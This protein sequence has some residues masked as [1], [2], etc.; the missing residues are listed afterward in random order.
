MYSWVCQIFF[1][2]A[3]AIVYW[4]WWMADLT[5]DDSGII[6]LISHVK[7]SSFSSK[8]Y[9]SVMDKNNYNRICRIS[10]K[11]EDI[12]ESYRRILSLTFAVWITIS[13]LSQDSYS[14]RINFSVTPGFVRMVSGTSFKSTI[15]ITSYICKWKNA[16]L[17]HFVSTIR[18]AS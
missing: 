18:H 14:I 2:Y 10:M 17:V 3:E 8:S 9:P 11:M 6:L 13:P 15:S 1:V 4:R 12:I 16:G 5:H 7:S